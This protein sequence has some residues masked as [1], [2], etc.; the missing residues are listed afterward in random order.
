MSFCPHPASD[1]T[2]PCPAYPLFIMYLPLSPAPN[3]PALRL[4][5]AVVS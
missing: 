5:P 3:T 4:L 1:A 2:A